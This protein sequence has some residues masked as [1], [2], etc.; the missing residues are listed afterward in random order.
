MLLRGE[1]LVGELVAWRAE[2]PIYME[3]G[4]ALEA[5]ARLGRETDD[6]DELLLIPEW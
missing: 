2:P 1:S 4:T 6:D 3:S 5:M